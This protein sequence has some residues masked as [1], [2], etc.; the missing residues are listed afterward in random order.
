MQDAPQRCPKCDGQMEPGFLAN[1]LP[2][3]GNQLPQWAP[4][5]PQRSFWS[6]IMVPEE[7]CLPIGAFRCES[8]GYLEFYAREE[9][10]TTQ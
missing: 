5:A 3:F 4:G 8:C 7:S 10:G 9:F 6:G 2:P 1:S